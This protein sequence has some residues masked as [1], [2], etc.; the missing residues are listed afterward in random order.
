[1]VYI[2]YRVYL[3]LQLHCLSPCL[4]N[5]DPKWSDHFFSFFFLFFLWKW[6]FL[7]FTMFWPQFPLPPLFSVLPTPVN[8]KLT[9][10]FLANKMMYFKYYIDLLSSLISNL[11]LFKLKCVYYHKIQLRILLTF[12]IIFYLLQRNSFLVLVLLG[13]S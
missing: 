7:S 2:R 10:Q 13:N 12:K 4:Q 6:I 8:P 11:K 9:E 1:M 5:Q 3:F